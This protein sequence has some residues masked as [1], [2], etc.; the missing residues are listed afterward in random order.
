MK[1]EGAITEH[2]QMNDKMA[3]IWE[4]QNINTLSWKRYIYNIMEEKNMVIS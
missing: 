3:L 1:Y 4:K 2:V